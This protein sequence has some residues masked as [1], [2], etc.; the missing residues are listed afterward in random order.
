MGNNDHDDPTR[1][2]L[3]LEEQEALKNSGLLPD[4]IDLSEYGD[5]DLGEPSAEGDGIHD[6]IHDDAAKFEAATGR[7]PGEDD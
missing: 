5:D 2:T 7:K 1:S 4:D 3:T 6:G